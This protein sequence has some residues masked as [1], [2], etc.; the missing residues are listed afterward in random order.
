MKR[1]HSFQFDN[2]QQYQVAL[3]A[4]WYKGIMLSIEGTNEAGQTLTRANL[5]DVRLYRD[6]KRIWEI[7]LEKLWYF[8]EQHQLGSQAFTSTVASTVSIA[9]YIPFSFMND[10]NVCRLGSNYTLEFSHADISA[11]LATTTLT[12][13]VQPGI[14]QEKY[15]PIYNNFSIRS[16]TQLTE[17]EKMNR[18][19]L[20]YV[21]VDFSANHTH[22]RLKKGDNYIYDMTDEESDFQTSLENPVASYAATAPTIP[23][24]LNLYKDR[25]LVG[26]AGNN[27]VAFGAVSSDTNTTGLTVEFE[28]NAAKMAH[29]ND[30]VNKIAREKAANPAEL[31]NI[32][33][34]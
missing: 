33:A 1:I 13:L 22:F 19:N 11:V 25:S 12:V 3:P 26:V 27:D 18:R 34:A 4:G 6:G 21:V 31:T 17:P 28:L 24:V 16:L 10:N 32:L 23:V 14:G 2:V 9:C 15:F 8:V 20:A 5:G 29:S 7:T 30:I